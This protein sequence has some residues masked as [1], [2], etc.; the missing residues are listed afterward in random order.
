MKERTK[1]IKVLDLSSSITGD[2][3]NFAIDMGN[4]VKE[5]KDDRNCP[6][7]IIYMME[8]IR[9]TAY[10]LRDSTGNRISNIFYSLDFPS[11]KDIEDEREN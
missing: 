4:I 9:R 2:L 6:Q 7:H 1:D 8:G 11:K 5:L 10:D 3:N